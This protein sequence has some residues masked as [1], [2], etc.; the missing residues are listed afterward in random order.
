[1]TQA[2]AEADHLPIYEDLV[3]ERGDVVAEAQM[4]AAHTE[5]QAAELLQGPPSPSVNRDPRY[6]SGP[7]ERPSG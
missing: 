4:A 7:P 6:S 2:S 3:R 5:N 1:M